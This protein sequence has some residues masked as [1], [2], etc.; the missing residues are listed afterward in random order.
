MNI[1][2]IWGSLR[3][4]VE[5]LNQKAL[6]QKSLEVFPAEERDIIEF[7][8]QDSQMFNY[9]INTL[10]S[11][12]LHHFFSFSKTLYISTQEIRFEGS[13]NGSYQAPYPGDFLSRDVYLTL[14]GIEM[15]RQFGL[16]FV[17]KHFKPSSQKHRYIKASIYKGLSYAADEEV[18]VQYYD[19]I[20]KCWNT[21]NMSIS[22][23]Y[24][25]SQI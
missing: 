8:A 17:E 4:A 1:N 25:K 2:E 9:I 7:C 13:S 22:L 10:S 6:V 12:A 21:D 3:S 19:L 14:E 24:F 15:F 20:K 11:L 16:D 23:R 5:S 18:S